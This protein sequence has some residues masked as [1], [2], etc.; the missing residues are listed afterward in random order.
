MGLSEFQARL[1]YRT[2]SR[3]DKATQ[4]NPVGRGRGWERQNGDKVNK[5]TRPRKNAYQVKALTLAGRFSYLLWYFQSYASRVA[6]LTNRCSHGPC[7]ILGAS[8]LPDECESSLCAVLST[9]LVS[10]SPGDPQE[11]ANVNPQSREASGL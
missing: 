9:N 1:V 6:S 7:R 11:L 4:R 2:P 10:E 5:A 8:G 3:T